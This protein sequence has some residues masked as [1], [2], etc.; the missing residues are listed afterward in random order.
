MKFLSTGASQTSI[1][2]ELGMLDIEYM[3]SFLGISPALW[4]YILALPTRQQSRGE[5]E[6]WEHCSDGFGGH[7]TV[8][9][10]WFD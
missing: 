3:Q 4:W 8:W 10:A 2:Q 7:G 5:S 1:Y 9:L 6:E